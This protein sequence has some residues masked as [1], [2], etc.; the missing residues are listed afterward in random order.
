L[1]EKVKIVNKE[2]DAQILFTVLRR[3]WWTPILL[4]FLFWSVAFFYL[5]YTKSTYDSSMVIQLGSEDKAKDVME[6]VGE[7]KGDDN[8]SEEVE[9]MRSQLLFNRALSTLNLRTS[10]FS[11]GAV[12][13]EELYK[14]GLITI[15]PEKLLDSNLVNTP[16]ALTV[17][18]HNTIYLD[19]T[20]NGNKFGAHGKLNQHIR[21]QHFDILIN[22]S[23]I[24]ELKNASEVNKMYFQFNNMASVSA[25]LLPGLQILPLNDAAK[26]IQILYTGENPQICHDIVYAVG[27][28][29]MVF[30]E[31]VKRKGSENIIKFIDSQMY[32]GINC[33]VRK[34]V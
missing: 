17:D 20:Y 23:S 25:R 7:N 10:V 24:Q 13:T 32:W 6:I 12:L 5:R 3:H 9:L 21:N 26:T 1:K 2:F 27:S 29:F 4:V 30:D 31:E 34:I 28:V 22:S 18:D 8:M 33:P 11:K 14:T 19:Y 15:V 16:I